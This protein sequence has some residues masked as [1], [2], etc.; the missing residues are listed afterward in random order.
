[1]Y[2]SVKH[3][4]QRHWAEKPAT[5]I[6]DFKPGEA[7]QVVFGAG[8]V[9]VDQ[10][11]GGVR[12]TWFFVMTLAFSRHQ[13]PEFV[14]Y[15]KVETWLGFH[16]RAFEFF[17]GVPSRVII[18]NPKCAIVRV[19]YHNPEVQ[20][21]YAA[22]CAEGKEEN[23]PVLIVGPCGTGMSHLA[24]DIPT[25]GMSICRQKSAKLL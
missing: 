16:R 8:P 24:Q 1:M 14:I 5:I 6:L 18:D 19:C 10:E 25:P 13:S 3:F 2:N 22:E 9:L 12:K 20:R 23:A 21:A 11:T 17:G 15:L 4:L 7:A